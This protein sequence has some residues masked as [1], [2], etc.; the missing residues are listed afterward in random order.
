M[1]ILVS[2]Q[3]LPARVDNMAF[4]HGLNDCPRQSNSMLDLYFGY[5]DQ[6]T[7]GLLSLWFS[8]WKNNGV[9]SF[10]LITANIKKIQK[11]NF[12]F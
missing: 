1:R 12:Q 9:F 2:N 4:A 3:A 5:Q 8:N 7:T 6:E 10:R 11:T